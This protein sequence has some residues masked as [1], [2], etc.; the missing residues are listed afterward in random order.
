MGCGDFTV[1]SHASPLDIWTAGTV[2]YDT[3]PDNYRWLRAC[4]AG[5][6][7]A[8]HGAT[9]RLS[10][11]AGPISQ[12]AR[13]SSACNVDRAPSCDPGARE[14]QTCVIPS[15]VCQRSYRSML[16]FSCSPPSVVLSFLAIS[17]VQD[18]PSQSPPLTPHVTRRQLDFQ[19]VAI[20]DGRLRRQ[21]PKEDAC[22]YG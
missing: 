3:S 15:H 19:K 13:S 6:G 9:L 8:R 18:L 20:C 1:S 21:H 14:E 12:H 7:R 2:P 22:V 10:G 11:H 5:C 4:R 16:C 17:S